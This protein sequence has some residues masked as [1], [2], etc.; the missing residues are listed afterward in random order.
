VG[1][2]FDAVLPGERAALVGTGRGLLGALVADRMTAAL[3]WQVVLVRIADDA[4]RS[5]LCDPGPDLAEAEGDVLAW[6][7]PYDGEDWRWAQ[8]FPSIT[9]EPPA[10]RRR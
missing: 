8:R 2:A 5:L 10:V 7:E 1:G 4:E 9:L 6:V 3:T